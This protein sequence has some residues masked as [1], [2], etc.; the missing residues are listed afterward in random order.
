MGRSPAVTDHEPSAPPTNQ[1]ADVTTRKCT[2]TVP[3]WWNS[4]QPSKEH[5]HRDTDTGR[6]LRW[7]QST[8]HSSR[9]GSTKTLIAR[10]QEYLLLGG[11]RAGCNAVLAEQSNA[12]LSPPERPYWGV[13]AGAAKRMSEFWQ[14]E[15]SSR[16][17]EFL[18]DL[19]EQGKIGLAN[20]GE[21]IHSTHHV[22]WWLQWL[23]W[24]SLWTNTPQ[25][26]DV[27]TWNI[28]P[29]AVDLSIHLVAQTLSKGAAVVMLQEVSFHPGERKANKKYSG[30]DRAG[31]LVRHGNEPTGAGWTR[32]DQ[33]RG[34]QQKL[35]VSV[36]VLSGHLPAQGCVQ[37][38]HSCGLG[39]AVHT[40][41][42]EAHADGP[43]VLPMGS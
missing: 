37:K 16:V 34:I 25:R 31:I 42:A 43:N 35:R 14:A 5:S 27:I 29:Q 24:E 8:H 30:K 33:S 26:S 18:Q 36:G 7:T 23:E 6:L 39:G 4:S 22:A 15:E 38:A 3:V 11:D 41:D 17:P 28:G 10:K 2:G 1:Q 19:R 9:G 12:A 40:E 20:Y 21:N 32:R 13:W